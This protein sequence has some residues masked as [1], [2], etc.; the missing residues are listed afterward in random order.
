VISDSVLNPASCAQ[1]FAYFARDEMLFI[2]QEKNGKKQPF[3][4]KS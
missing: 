2:L 4:E 3:A 1:A